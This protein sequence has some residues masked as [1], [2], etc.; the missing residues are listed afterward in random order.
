MTQIHQ[1][2]VLIVGAG[3]SG[4]FFAW[5]LAEKGFKVNVIEKKELGTLGENID[6][7]HFDEIRFD[8][9]NIPLPKGDELIGYYPDGLA[10]PPDGDRR[11][12]KYVNYAFYVMRLPLFINRLQ[13]YAKEAGVQ[14]FEKTTFEEPIIE[15][16]NLKGIKAS[17]NDTTVEFHANL[18]VDCSG[19]GSVVRVSLSPEFN[20]ET[21]PIKSQDM[22]YVILK[23]VN[24]IEEE[25]FPRGLNFYPF[26]KTF[27]NPSYGHG[28]ILGVGQPESFTNAVRVQEDFLLER[29]PYKYKIIK[30]AKGCTPFRRP[31][32][33]LVADNFIMLGDAAFLTK[34]FSGEGVTSSFTACQIAVEEVIKLF[35]TKEFNRTNL[36]PINVRYFRDQ[37]AKFAELLAQLPGAAELT[38]KDVNYLFR[39]DI[40]FSGEAL[41]N[42]NRDFEN[43][44][45]FFSL[46]SMAWKLTWGIISQQFSFRSFRKL[47]TALSISKKLRKHYENYPIHY[48]DFNEW[49]DKAYLLWKQV[50]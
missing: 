2:D 21:D 42:M 25:D 7:F 41:T 49:V 24:E 30:E 18:V 37:G 45:S 9:F 17:S 23:Y 44:I 6:I 46:L 33:S 3:T 34:P 39:K 20:I 36:W 43:K 5:K 50:Y 27:C 31:P 35:S 12:A 11:L 29:F 13:K 47:M 26:H 14:F 8:Q 32:F 28:A 15:L 16:E 38:R 40:I 48:I 19:I 1:S 4:S 10:W 22:L